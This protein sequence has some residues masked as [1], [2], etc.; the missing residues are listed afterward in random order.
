MKTLKTMTAG[1]YVLACAY[2]KIAQ[3]DTPEA[4]SKKKT[5]QTQAQAAMN[6]KYSYQKCLLCIAE[7]FP[8][9][10]FVSLTYDDEHLSKNR[11]EAKKN[12][13]RFIRAMRKEYGR[14]HAVFGYM[15]STEGKHGEKRLHHHMIVAPVENA[16]E[17]YKSMWKN[18]LADVERVSANEIQ[19]LARYFTKEASE[20][21]RKVGERAWTP[22]KGLRQPITETVTVPDNCGIDPPAGSVLLDRQAYSSEYGK[23]KRYSILCRKAIIYS[24]YQFYKVATRGESSAGNAPVVALII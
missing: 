2:P 18:G 5:A 14:Y 16:E 12:I 11:S 1:R 21:S 8:D 3:K 4:R 19:A 23:P 9:G 22:S 13:Q 15:Y 24:N 17:L 20:D 10:F 6:L 7:N